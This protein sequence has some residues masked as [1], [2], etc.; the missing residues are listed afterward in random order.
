MF[1]EYR[2]CMFRSEW[3]KDAKFKSLV[4]NDRTDWCLKDRKVETESALSLVSNTVSV[5]DTNSDTDNGSDN[6]ST[7]RMSELRFLSRR[8]EA[9]VGHMAMITAVGLSNTRWLPGFARVPFF[10]C[11]NKVS[12]ARDALSDGL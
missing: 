12:M 6:E 2:D 7:V 5:S 11:N 4:A 3:L 10:I 8:V 9:S 1:C